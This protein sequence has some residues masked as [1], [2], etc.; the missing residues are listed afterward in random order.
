MGCIGGGGGEGDEG[1]G[2]VWGSGMKGGGI[3]TNGTRWK[4]KRVE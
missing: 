4:A 3:A 1:V 2:A